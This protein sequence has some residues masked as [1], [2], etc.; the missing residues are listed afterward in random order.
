MRSL[1][2]N[3]RGPAP[4]ENDDNNY[5]PVVRPKKRAFRKNP[6]AK[7]SYRDRKEVKEPR[8]A[9]LDTYLAFDAN[10][11]KSTDTLRKY[12]EDPPSWG[13]SDCKIYKKKTY[14]SGRSILISGDAVNIS[15][16]KT[17]FDKLPGAQKNHFYR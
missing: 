15:W 14:F 10:S 1:V 11:I 8:R 12:T 6:R 3:Q 4:R 17:E 9:R 7:R 5:E 13:Y 16:C 2:R